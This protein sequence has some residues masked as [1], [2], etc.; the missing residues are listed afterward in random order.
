MQEAWIG[1]LGVGIGSA[2]TLIASVIVPWIR[3]SLDR[4]RRELEQQRIEL[5][6]SLLAAQSA[7]LEYRQHRNGAGGA[8]A[9]AKFGAAVNDLTVRVTADEHAIIDV[10]YAMVAMVQEPRPGVADKLGEA[11]MVLNLWFRGD[12]ATGEVIP[13]VERRAKLKFSD[14]RRTVAAVS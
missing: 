10:L 6:S 8:A 12:I 5:R 1:L 2:V 7:L 9:L 3:D 13:E 11:M 4:R 14:D